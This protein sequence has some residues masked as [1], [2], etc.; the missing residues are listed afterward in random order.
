MSQQPI[1]PSEIQRLLALKRHEVP[2][3]GYFNHFSDKVLSRIE[4]ETVLQRTS[5]WRRL[6]NML[7]PNPWIACAY[8]LALAGI[9]SWGLLQTPTT[10]TAAQPAPIQPTSAGFLA[11]FPLPDRTTEAESQTPSGS[12]AHTGQQQHPHPSFNPVF[13]GP[14]GFLT[15]PEGHKVQNVGFRR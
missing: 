9:L 2:P 3:P 7:D 13:S 15:G 11:G 5:V 1:D 10:S 6:R 4:A 12:T 14:P 8:G